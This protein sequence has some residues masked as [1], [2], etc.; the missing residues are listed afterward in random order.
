M[1]ASTPA[2]AG[3]VVVLFA[4]GMIAT[5]AYSLNQSSGRVRQIER[6]HQEWSE[7]RAHA[8]RLAADQAALAEAT[9]EG[10]APPLAEWFRVQ[11]PAWA[12]ELKDAD[13]ERV[14]ADWSLR[15]VQLTIA[16]APLAEFGETVAALARGPA[17]WRAVELN[18][19][20]I[21]AE[22]GF[23]RAVLIVEGLARAPVATP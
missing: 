4:A 20:A 17:P 11:R 3:A 8:A 14:N 1:K 9:R 18:L 19:S 21:D 15:R 16:R 7:L 6:R 13:S 10:G 5:A 23:A 22:P 12:I 2:R